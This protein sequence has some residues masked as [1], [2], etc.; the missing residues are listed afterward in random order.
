[1]T[2]LLDLVTLCIMQ[3]ERARESLRAAKLCLDAGHVN[4]A[5]SRA[6]YAMFQSAQVALAGVGVSRPTWSHPALQAA[7]TTE[8]IHRRKVLPAQLRDYLSSGLAVRHAAD[9]GRTGV[10]RKVAE[11]IVRRAA[12]FVRA[13]E[14]QNDSSL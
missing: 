4:S 13:V 14:V 8:L 10:S 7:L 1:M 5:A 9:Y 11:R 12:E 3:I 6:F 2:L